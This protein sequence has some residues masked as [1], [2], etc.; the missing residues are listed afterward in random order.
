[1]LN[2]TSNY[3]P[4]YTQYLG[5]QR[6]C[7]LKLRGPPGPPGPQGPSAIG[8]R[9]STGLVGPTGPIGPIG[10]IGPTTIY[11]DII[12]LN[13][14]SNNNNFIILPNQEYFVQYY[15]L[16][17]EDISLDAIIIPGDAL[18]VCYQANI[19]IT[20][21]SNCSINYPN[22]QLNGITYIE[23]NQPLNLN[24]SDNNSYKSTI[25]TILNGGTD[26]LPMYYLTSVSYY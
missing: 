15:S 24:A 21:N 20:T 6:C 14:H 25:I 16:D 2:F 5:S 3:H 13:I 1:M 19:L 26:V 10:P 22:I 9:G 4:D 8:I 11:P 12:P 18:P 17:L 23:Y 7:N